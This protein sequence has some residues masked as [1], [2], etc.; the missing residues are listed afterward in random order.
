MRR[1]AVIRLAARCLLLGALLYAAGVTY[2]YFNPANPRPLVDHLFRSLIAAAPAVRAV[3]DSER[4]RREQGTDAPASP[5]SS[6]CASSATPASG[7]TG[8]PVLE[9]CAAG[10]SPSASAGRTTPGH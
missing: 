10:P 7:R 3:R 6:P 2:W 9:P 1:G 8:G 5:R 4:K